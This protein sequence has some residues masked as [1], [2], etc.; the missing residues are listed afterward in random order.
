MLYGLSDLARLSRKVGERAEDCQGA[1]GN[2]SVKLDDTRM[3]IKA[4]GIRLRDVTETEGFAMADW[5]RLSEFYSATDGTERGRAEEIARESQLHP[6]GFSEGAPSVEA[7]LHS[8]LKKFVI[9]THSVYAN[10]LCCSEEGR[11]YA[12]TIFGGANF[13]TAFVAEAEPGYE[14]TVKVRDARAAL[15]AAGKDAD[16]FFLRNHG[17][18]VH[19]DEST[20]AFELHRRV[21][22]QIMKYF[23]IAVGQITSDLEELSE[24]CFESHSPL[25]QEGIR[26]GELSVRTLET[27][28]LF[29]EQVIYLNNLLRKGNEKVLGDKIEYHAAERVARAAEE[30]AVAWMFLMRTMRGLGLTPR[31]MNEK[32]VDALRSWRAD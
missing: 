11:E 6:I 12:E 27:F 24:D 22:D 2:T 18:V 8:L 30:T 26:T 9:H 5:R 13:G 29:P 1:S 21:E 16:V 31:P 19:A 23:G 20:Q 32:E 3:A 10:L 15:R 14:L 25:V 28:P 4:S 17:L 7:G